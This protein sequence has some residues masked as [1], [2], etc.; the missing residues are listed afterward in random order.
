MAKGRGGQNCR[1]STRIEGLPPPPARPSRLHPEGTDADPKGHAAPNSE[2][3]RRG[4]QSLSLALAL[5]FSEVRQARGRRIPEG[6]RHER[7]HFLRWLRPA[8]P[9][10]G[11]QDAA[12]SL[13]K[14]QRWPWMPETGLTI[15]AG[16]RR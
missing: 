5:S 12:A 11:Y 16:N 15:A 9:R 2:P 10:Q 14:S 8:P 4:S 13:L 1:T 7:A 3:I 6:L